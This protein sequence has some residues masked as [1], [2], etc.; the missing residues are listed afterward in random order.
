MSTFS[1]LLLIKQSEKE[2][3][4]GVIFTTCPL[5]IISNHRHHHHHQKIIKLHKFVSP[6]TSII[7]V[8][9]YIKIQY[10]LYKKVTFHSR[11]IPYE[12][13]LISSHPPP[14][15][16]QVLLA[17][18]SPYYRF[19]QCAKQP[20]RGQASHRVFNPDSKTGAETT[21]NSW[22]EGHR[23]FLKRYQE[24]DMRWRDFTLSSFHGISVYPCAHIHCIT[25]L[26]NTYILRPPNNYFQCFL[27]FIIFTRMFSM[28]YW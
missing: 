2:R 7:N 15:L 20:T 21:K 16:H 22:R 6:R 14:H 23:H 10:K 4:R 17:S 8:I 5:V 24:Q 12:Y 27:G 26:H 9:F 19:M 11:L 25:Y 13:S 1:R 28:I 3:E 18:D